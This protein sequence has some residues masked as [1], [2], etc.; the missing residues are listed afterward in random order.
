MI[1][2]PHSFVK[3]ELVPI[4]MIFVDESEY[5]W[6]EERMKR[7]KDIAKWVLNNVSND[8][9][10]ILKAALKGLYK[11]LKYESIVLTILKVSGDNGTMKCEVP[12]DF[13]YKSSIT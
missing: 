4:I 1:L 13:R 2:F 8:F 12:F 5:R 10:D 6:T 3:C 11:S 7:Q 9:E